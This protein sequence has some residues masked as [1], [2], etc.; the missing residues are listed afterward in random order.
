MAPA[1]HATG[2]LSPATLT[3]SP[4]AVHAT[5]VGQ[6]AGAASSSLAQLAPAKER[7][8][9]DS[10]DWNAL[11]ID[12]TDGWE[13]GGAEDASAAYNLS[14]LSPA[15]SLAR[16]MRPADASLA[17]HMEEACAG[18]LAAECKDFDRLVLQNNLISVVLSGSSGSRIAMRCGGGGYTCCSFAQTMLN[19]DADRSLRAFGARHPQ[20][21]QRLLGKAAGTS[22]AMVA[23]DKAIS[24]L[25]LNSNSL[26]IAIL[27]RL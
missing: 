22:V 17:R 4:L 20:T 26:W 25:F 11:A 7:W 27:K 13:G 23:W 18:D 14:S 19:S 21:W 3:G 5:P 6:Q 15:Q 16:S 8:R 12:G 24:T 2:R 10:T 9:L 1:T